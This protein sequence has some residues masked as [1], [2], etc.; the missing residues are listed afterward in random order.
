VTFYITG[1]YFLRKQWGEGLLMLVSSPLLL[2]F[3]LAMSVTC[4]VAVLEGLLTKG[5]EFVRTPKGGG[6]ATGGGLVACLRSRTM[7]TAITVV[8]IAIGLVMLG[9]AVYFQRNEMLAIALVLL[10]KAA[11]FLGV[12][13]LSTPDLFPRSAARA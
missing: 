9:G 2:A 12:A 13:A 1:Q 3:G 8:E 10:V 11:G 4:S 5:G 6:T 7:F